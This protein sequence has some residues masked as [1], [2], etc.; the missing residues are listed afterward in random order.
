MRGIVQVTCILLLGLAIGCARPE[1]KAQQSQQ[2]QTGSEV[3]QKTVEQPAKGFEIKAEAV[4]RV[5]QWR[6]AEG[7]SIMLTRGVSMKMIDGSLTGLEAEAGFEL[8]VVRLNVTRLVEGATLSLDDVS[9]YDDKGKKYPSSVGGL[10]ALGKEANE[11][12]EFAFAVPIR[13]PLKQ[14]Q[15]AKDISVELK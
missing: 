3:S 6:P 4:R 11:S 2:G 9:A 1:Q 8:A 14:I 15:L 7:G 12:R 10:P 13:T 5:K